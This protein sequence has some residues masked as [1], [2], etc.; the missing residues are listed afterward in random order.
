MRRCLDLARRGAGRT[1]PNPMVG[2]VVARG[3][4]VVAEAYHRRAGGPHAEVA[5]LRRAGAA[6]RGAT[7]YA[8]LE[9][10]SHF[11]RTP[12]CVDAILA[13]G[14]RR[15]VAAHGDP[16][17]LV[18]GRGFA[19]LRRAGVKVEVGLLR[20]EAEHLNERYLT[21]ITRRRPFVLVKAG[22]TVD[23]RI[24]TA[25]G[26]SKWITSSRSRAMAHAL[27]AAYD[28][29]M[30]GVGTVLADDPLLT[31]RKGAAAS[32][33]TWPRQ[34]VRAIM[35]A[36]LR[37]PPRAR[38]L[39]SARRGDGGGL[40]IYTRSRPDAARM[41]SLIRAGAEVVPLHGGRGGNAVD[42]G[43]A[44]R[45][46]AARGVTSVMIEGGGE[47]IWSAFEAGLVDKVAL[48]I[49]PVIVGGRGAVGLAGGTGVKSPG[50][51]IRL[52]ERVLTPV[53]D[54]LLLEAYVARRR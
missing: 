13:A 43:A 22:M 9:P 32:A 44:L 24:A 10:C 50:R 37:T 8:N 51:A 28:A 20:R 35:D 15:V 30:V 49:A 6:A 19:A 7:L 39:R 54:D 38:L 41:R 27:R 17:P 23:G 46:L 11:G 31:A 2:A 33:R 21:W 16:F 5:A 53:G 4:K 45:D 36:R 12:P 14:I 3:D 26:V 47:I 40:I 48:F 18:S 1:S 29:V 52:V 25:A 34:P 42:L